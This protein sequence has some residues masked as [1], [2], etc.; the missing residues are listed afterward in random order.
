MN[1]KINKGSRYEIAI[2]KSLEKNLERYVAARWFAK[3]S[4]ARRKTIHILQKR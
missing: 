2:K 4:Q 1:S 3:W